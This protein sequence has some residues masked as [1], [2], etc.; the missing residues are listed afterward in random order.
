[1][2]TG[3]TNRILGTKTAKLWKKK[4]KDLEENPELTCKACGNQG[5][6]SMPFVTWQKNMYFQVGS[7]PVGLIRSDPEM[8]SVLCHSCR[9]EV[10]KELEAAGDFFDPEPE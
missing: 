6:T 2:D 9:L 4:F 7:D 1:M 8:Q 10:V 5:A 3:Q